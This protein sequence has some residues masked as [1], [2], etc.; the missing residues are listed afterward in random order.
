[1]PSSAPEDRLVTR[2][3]IGL[4]VR[5]HG[6]DGP[7]LLLL[8]G[9]GRTLADWAAVA[10]MLTARHRVVAMDL[11][12]HGRSESGPWTFPAVLDDVEAV[13]DAFALPHAL[14]VGHSLG[15]MVAALYALHH[16]AAPAAVNLDGHGYGR[17]EQYAGLDR[18]HVESRLAEVRRFA[19][20]AAGQE[21]PAEAMDVLLARQTSMAEDLGIPGTLFEAGLRRALA[22][23][24]DG[25]RY[26]RPERAPA[27]QMLA[28]MDQLD[29][30]G[31]YRRLTC[32]L[33]ICRA[34]RPNP[35]TP[36]LPWFDALMAAYATGLA[37]DL[38]RLATTHP[39][40]TVE[41][42]DATHAMLLERPD[43]V[44]AL[45]LTFAARHTGAR[46]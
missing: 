3:G 32:P 28:A 18:D 20:R 25:R 41:E 36:G 24:E 2:D 44:A 30:F 9:A 17:P 31:V 45:I 37:R 38:A 12:A 19:A 26:L 33:L 1:M 16:P 22:E 43:D 11:R 5:D 14:P 34:A 10:P 8:H 35:P 27:L 4:A 23:C 13:L 7:P 6:G 29:L 15:G 42:V 21:L 40:V 46:R 39:H